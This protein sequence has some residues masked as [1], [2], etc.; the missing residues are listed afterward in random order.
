MAALKIDRT[1][2]LVLTLDT[3]A[4][5]AYVH[6]PPLPEEVFDTYAVT[7]T[8]AFAEMTEMGGQWFTRMGPRHAAR[9]VKKVALAQGVWDSRPADMGRGLEAYVGMD[10][11]FL[12]E[13]RRTA[14]VAMAG[15]DGWETMPLQLAI[16]GGRLSAEDV[17]EVEQALAFFTVTYGSLGRK[18][19]DKALTTVFGVFGASLTPSGSTDWATSLPTLTPPEPIGGK[20]EASSIPR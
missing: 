18:E 14:T 17:N 9:V 6:C 1:L 19:A 7:L 20:A 11:G 5:P 12:A 16:D 13:T 2:N 10:V 8:M 3:D 4:G 15:E